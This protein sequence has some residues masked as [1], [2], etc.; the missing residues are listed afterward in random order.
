MKNYEV[1]K[2]QYDA[3]R[4]Y[5]VIR[6]FRSFNKVVQRYETKEQ[7]N[8]RAWSMNKKLEE[9]QL[10]EGKRNFVVL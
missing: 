8:K 7:A 5:A 1:Q 9:I 3:T 10:P 4:P 2:L 6:T